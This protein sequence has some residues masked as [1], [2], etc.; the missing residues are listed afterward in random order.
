M[1]VVCRKG[2]DATTVADV[3]ETAGVSRTTFYEMFRDKQDCFLASYDAVFDVLLYAVENAYR[4]TDGTW[5]ERIRAGIRALVTLLAQESDIARMAMVEVTSAGPAARQRYR[6]GLN[7]FLPFLD[8]GRGWSEHSKLLPATTSR[9]AIGAAAT[10]IFDEVRAGRAS[11][12][13][14]MLPELV[15]A[16]L[17]P[18][19]GPEAAA[20]EMELEAAQLAEAPA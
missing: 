20:R 8:E 16:V 17:M 19:I 2:Y 3:I 1:F 7:R 4:K 9:L 14:R 13:E 5:P 12:L 11:E 6:D 10:L 18:Y 15:F